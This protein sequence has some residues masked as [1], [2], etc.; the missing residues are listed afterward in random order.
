M[1]VKITEHD[2][3][4]KSIFQMY[5]KAEFAMMRN[6][7]R[8]FAVMA[9]GKMNRAS[10]IASGSSVEREVDGILSEL[11]DLRISSTERAIRTAY[12]ESV[13]AAA[14]EILSV[15]EDATMPPND[16]NSSKSGGV[17]DE[18][19]KR[20]DAAD[21]RLKRQ[22]KVTYEDIVSRVSEAVADG[23]GLTDAIEKELAHLADTGFPGFV[24]VSG[25]NWNIATY[26]ETTAVSALETAVIKGF[27]HTL[28]LNNYDL[29]LIQGHYGGCPI[30]QA[31]NGVVISITGS[32]KGYPT[33]DE[34]IAAGC[35]H[36]R[37]SHHLRLY[38]EGFGD[39]V[40]FRPQP[41]KK[42]LPG[43][44]LTQKQRR[45]EAEIRRWK[46]RAAVSITPMGEKTAYA[47]IRYYQREIREIL[48]ENTGAA[49]LRWR[50]GSGKG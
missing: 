10:M 45:L 30:C 35:F 41:I 1:S 38:R 47:H 14:D 40:R 22:Y 7:S 25:R 50:E 34:A 8:R 4:A 32:T 42:P 37:C 48:K 2:R 26:A 17:L 3:L 16:E 13:K 46:R 5:E 29:V 27:M 24:D 21:N 15:Q 11:R 23:A 33:L 19:T 49:R 18:L 43:Y 44:S 6:Y 20:L 12:E 9:A 28:E 31:W 36:P 39:E